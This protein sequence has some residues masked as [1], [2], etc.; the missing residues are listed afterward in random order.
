MI[1]L[2]SVSLPFPQAEL[3]AD[4]GGTRRI[5]GRDPVPEVAIARSQKDARMLL[6]G[7]L[8]KAGGRLL[9]F[10]PNDYFETLLL[11]L[12]RD[13]ALKELAVVLPGDNVLGGEHL[14]QVVEFLERAG[15]REEDRKTL[16]LSNGSI[17]GSVEGIPLT[18]CTLHGLAKQEGGE[19]LLALDTSILPVVY[20]NEVKTPMLELARKL[21]LTL[22]DRRISAERVVLFDTVGREDFPLE[23]G[24]VAALL[25]EMIADPARFSGTLPEKWKLLGAAESAYFFSRYPEATELYRRYLQAAPK[26]ASACYKIAMMALRDLDVDMALQ[27]VNKAVDADPLY[28]RAYDGMG[29]YLA[30]KELFDSAERLYLAGL[31]RF[32][33][34]PSLANGLALL[35][36]SRGEALR[37]A[38]D[39]GAAAVLF[40]VASDVEGA[41]PSL[42]GK[43]KALADSLTADTAK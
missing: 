5:V 19:F 40:A 13:G 42:R 7:E 15:V 10:S 30:G 21:V 8:P 11:P 25:K 41:D 3:S 29:R 17:A 20:R 1:F 32:P 43:A 24:Y 27:W 18:L 14:A 12:R 2:L 37:E 26:D 23:Q 16:R 33:K 39:A 28:K 9:L 35:Y 31:D 34:D 22:A 38:G 36:L 4:G 6:A